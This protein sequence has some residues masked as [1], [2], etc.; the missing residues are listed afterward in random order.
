MNNLLLTNESMTALARL[1]ES[2]EKHNG[3]DMYDHSKLSAWDCERW[4]CAVSCDCSN[5][6]D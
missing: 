6:R 4:D 1:L 3:C 2:A 5:C